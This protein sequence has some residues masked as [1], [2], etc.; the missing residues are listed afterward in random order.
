MVKHIYYYAFA[1]L[2]IHNN[3]ANKQ[4]QTNPQHILSLVVINNK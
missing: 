2:F 4:S 1:R 3:L